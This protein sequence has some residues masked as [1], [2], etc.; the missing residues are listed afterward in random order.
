VQRITNL[1]VVGVASCQKMHSHGPIAVRFT[2]RKTNPLAIRMYIGDMIVELSRE[3]FDLAIREGHMNDC[4]V[5][6]Q[7]DVTYKVPRSM[8]EVL[9]ISW[10]APINKWTDEG[11]G[12]YYVLVKRSEIYAWLRETYVQVPRYAEFDALELDSVI[13]RILEGTK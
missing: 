13:H 5:I 1:D 7:A 4:N 6:G 8:P 11:D 12:R 2:F 10:L 9:S 3:T